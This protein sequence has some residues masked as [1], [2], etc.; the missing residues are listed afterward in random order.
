MEVEYNLSNKDEVNI[1]SYLV[2]TYE[3]EN[4]E[5]KEFLIDYS[6]LASNEQINI[7]NLKEG[8][9]ETH[10]VGENEFFQEYLNNIQ[11]DLEQAQTQYDGTLAS[12]NE[13]DVSASSYICFHCTRYQSSSHNHSSGC[14]EAFAWVCGAVG[15]KTGLPGFIACA[16]VAV[17]S[18]WVPAY[19]ICVDGFWSDTCPIQ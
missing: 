7:H 6:N 10:N 4:G 13:G 16:G 11:N 3:Y 19:R 14:R 2:Y 12:L 18:C 17:V 5:F 9:I 1:M 8:S 15:I